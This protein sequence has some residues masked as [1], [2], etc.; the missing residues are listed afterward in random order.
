MKN[1]KLYVLIVALLTLA[2]S[3]PMSA[4]VPT[5]LLPSGFVP[6]GTVISFGPNLYVGSQADGSIYR[7]NVLTGDGDTLVPAVTPQPSMALGLSYDSRTDYL[8]VAGGY[9][10]PLRVYDAETGDLV[11]TYS[12]S[13]PVSAD[14]PGLGPPDY[15]ANDVVVTSHG[16]YISDSANPCIYKATLG[17]A[18]RLPEEEELEIITLKDRHLLPG[19]GSLP[20]FMPNGIEAT[21]NGKQLF[22]V[23]GAGGG[24]YRIN[25][26][27]GEWT[28]LLG[29]LNGGDGLLLIGRRLYVTQ[30]TG[31]IVSVVELQKGKGTARV[32]RT[33]EDPSLNLPATL[34]AFG[35]YLYVANAGGQNVSRLPR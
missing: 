4:Q 31:N 22:L 10:F 11:R 21:P 14:C 5:I 25:P 32:V 26:D 19:G 18:G 34:A 24:L 2:L 27:N 3:G 9:F 8:F 12:L 13:S 1:V 20:D 15:F 28:K 29:G 30:N 6:E 7:A 17:P 35:P 16:V 23:D 33:I